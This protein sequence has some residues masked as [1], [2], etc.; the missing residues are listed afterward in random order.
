L[1][2]PTDLASVGAK[3]ERR[4]EARRLFLN[5]I[6]PRREVVGV[7][8]NSPPIH[9]SVG[10][11]IERREEAR[12]LFLNLIHPR[13]EVVGVWQNEDECRISNKECRSSKYLRRTSLL[14]IPC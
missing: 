14:D 2:L 12:R 11:K 1:K 3:I 4:E 8:S 6:H 10:A 5:L 9:A 13:R 7:F